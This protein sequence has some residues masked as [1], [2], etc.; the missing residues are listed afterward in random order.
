MASRYFTTIHRWL[1]VVSESL[2]YERLPNTFTKP[3]AD[4]SLLSLSM[5][6]IT[7]IPSEQVSKSMLALYTLVKSSTAIVEA[8]NVNTVEVVQARLLV[9]LFEYGHG[10]PAAYISLGATARAAAAIK[11]NGTVDDP[12]SPSSNEGLK[13]WWGIV[14]LDRWIFSLQLRTW[15]ISIRYYTLE[16]GDGP[17]A[18]QDLG[19]PRHL[20]R[21][22]NV[23][24]QQ[25]SLSSTT[26]VPPY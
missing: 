22:G 19:S 7:T 12:C 17:C 16:R 6:L 5:A 9:S 1:P 25:V 23:W 18:T 3:R 8:A 24:D 21:D 13:L 14:M 2:F 26:K 10:M 20:P 11:I 15:L 4:I